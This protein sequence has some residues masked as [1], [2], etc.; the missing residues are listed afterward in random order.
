MT[1]TAV[2]TE[3]SPFVSLKKLSCTQC[4]GELELHNRRAQYISCRYCGAVLDLN[5]ETYQIIEQLTNPQNYP[6]FSFIELGVELELFGI[7][8]IVIGRTRWQS[9]YKEYY[10]EYDDEDGWERGYSDEIWEYDEW[11]LLSQYKNYLYLIEDKKGFAIS[12]SVGPTAPNLPKTFAYKNINF[13]KNGA[14]GITQEYGANKILYFEGESTYL[15]KKGETAAFAMYQKKLSENDYLIGLENIPLEKFYGATIDCVFE[16]RIDSQQKLKEIEF[17]IEIPV[18]KELLRS[19]V[20]GGGDKYTQ[21]AGVVDKLLNLRLLFFMLTLGFAMLTLLSLRDPKKVA[22]KEF[23][24]SEV[25]TTLKP[26][27]SVDLLANKVYELQITV[28]SYKIDSARYISF[29]VTDEHNR[30]LNSFDCAF[31]REVSFECDY[32]GCETYTDSNLQNSFTFKVDEPAKI[33]IHAIQSLEDSQKERIS[34]EL[35]LY[36]SILLSRYFV[37][38]LCISGIS[39]LL[40]QVYLERNYWWH[41]AFIKGKRIKNEFELTYTQKK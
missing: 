17:F 20:I 30:I 23:F 13:I 39:L 24:S 36:S 41:S 7:R 19:A 31:W 12:A 32:E 27:L 14:P 11:L 3:P 35:S 5:S 26:L 16:W 2:T 9:E 40:L 33:T 18:S 25:D 1:A 6:P 8:Y 28:N 4:G 10:Q 37:L 38:G 21:Q 29:V 22:S 15:K 34:L